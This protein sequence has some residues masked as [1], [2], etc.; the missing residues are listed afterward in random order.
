MAALTHAHIN[1]RLNKSL[2]LKIHRRHLRQKMEN[3]G[4]KMT[5]QSG[6]EGGGEGRRSKEV[7]LMGGEP[8]CLA[9]PFVTWCD[10]SSRRRRKT[11][12][13]HLSIQL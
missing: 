4:R 11:N 8:R 12:T 2:W 13:K 6:E 7:P 3:E 10:F 1:E 9:S 5:I